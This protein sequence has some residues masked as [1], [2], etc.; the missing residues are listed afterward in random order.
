MRDLVAATPAVDRDPT[1]DGQE[2]V[3]S[4]AAHH[5]HLERGGVGALDTD[6]AC[7]SGAVDGERLV[8]EVEVHRA[9]ERPHGHPVQSGSEVEVGPDRRRRQRQGVV[10]A[11]EICMHD[12][13]RADVDDVV[14]GAPGDVDRPEA[15]LRADAHAFKGVEDRFGHTVAPDRSGGEVHVEGRP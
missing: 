5:P 8:G 3:V 6:Q 9:I 12:G 7:P 10:A 14:A 4:R 11:V 1:A 2:W 13:C 15:R